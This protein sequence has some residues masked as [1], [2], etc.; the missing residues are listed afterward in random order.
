M[1]IKTIVDDGIHTRTY[2]QRNVHGGMLSSIKEGFF[3]RR[4]YTRSGQLYELKG[5]GERLIASF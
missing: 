1:V 5:K 2:I 4:H 3:A